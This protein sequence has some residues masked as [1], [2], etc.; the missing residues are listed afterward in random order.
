MDSLISNVHAQVAVG[1]AQHSLPFTAA[2]LALKACQMTVNTLAQGQLIEEGEL[3]R[4]RKQGFGHLATLG[5]RVNHL[6]Q[7]KRVNQES[8]AP[9]LLLDPTN[10]SRTIEC[11][12]NVVQGLKRECFKQSACNS[13]VLDE[14]TTTSMQTC[15]VYVGSLSCTVEFEWLLTFIGQ[16]DT[17]G[18]ENAQAYFDS[19]K[20]LCEPYDIWSKLRAFGTDGCHSMRSTREHEG[21]DAR[22]AVGENFAAKVTEDFGSDRRPLFFH[23]LLHMLMLALGDALESALP[24][25]WIASVRQL[26]TYFRRSAKRKNAA[27]AAFA[28]VMGEVDALAGQFANLYE[29]HGWQMTFPKMYCATRWLGLATSTMAAVQSWGYL[30]R[31]KQTLID[32]GYGPPHADE[33][34]DDPGDDVFELLAYDSTETGNA[35]AAKSKRDVLLDPV[36]GITDL[37]YGLN[38]VI[39][40]LLKH[41]TLASTRLQ[42]TL[43]P[44]Q[45]RVARILGKL[46]R[47]L[48]LI[49]DD[50]YGAEYIAW[51]ELMLTDAIGKDD[52]VAGVDA[53][54]KQFASDIVS[55]MDQ[56]T[57]VYMPYYLA[58]ELIDPTAP[59]TVVSNTTWS[60]VEDLCDRYS[61]D[62][63]ELR[64][65]IIEMRGDAVD[66]NRR[67][68]QAC[69]QNLLCFYNHRVQ[70]VPVGSG[71]A[72]RY[73]KV[74]AYARVV[75]TLPFETV[76]IESLFS[77]MNYNKDKTRSSLADSKVAAIIHTKAAVPT[78]GDPTAVFAPNLILDTNKSLDHR[79]SW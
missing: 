72:K 44:I 5:E 24:E 48:L 66:L 9:P 39:C 31:M 64:S 51:R 40:S 53:I 67:D 50:V 60:A 19:I 78:L 30:R 25:H 56:R 65:E 68:A 22:G 76:L 18:S 47:S 3:Y 55:G 36:K 26:S 17:S 14:S 7:L 70:D 33:D 49:N 15:P 58:M 71:G 6:M 12:G 37:N 75:F 38:S 41:Y 79:L 29:T 62:F 45:H 10:V 69:K 20:K 57:K 63:N 59:D 2:T 1:F 21:V 42:T 77:I 16:T 54:G 34:V 11:H 27:R 52:L 43:Q 61:L 13:L 4:A 28:D 74:E 23:S 35:G 46:R 32:G 73:L 8:E